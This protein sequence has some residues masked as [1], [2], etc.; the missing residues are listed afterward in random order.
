MPE[1]YAARLISSKGSVTVES[2][3]ALSG[4][5]S[6]LSLK[7]GDYLQQGQTVVTGSGASTLIRYRDGS[8]LQ[9]GPDSRLLIEG[10]AFNPATSETVNHM[11]VNQGT[12]RYMSGF[13]VKK[14]SI[15][16]RTPSTSLGVRG[17]TVEGL[18]SADGAPGILSI[19]KGSGTMEN[20]AGSIKI[21]QSGM[22]VLKDPFTLPTAPDALPQEMQYEASVLFDSELGK[23]P[24]ELPE[25]TKE[26]RQQDAQR[27]RVSILEQKSR[28]AIGSPDGV[29]DRALEHLD[30][31]PLKPTSSGDQSEDV[32][33]GGFLGRMQ[34]I[35]VSWWDEVILFPEAVAATFDMVEKQLGSL[36]TAFKG[37]LLKPS[38]ETL[39]EEETKKLEQLKQ[40]AQ[41]R[42]PQAIAELARRNEALRQQNE[43]AMLKGVKEIIAGAAEIEDDPK[44]LARIVGSAAQAAKQNGVDTTKE[45][46]AGALSVEG[47][48]NTLEMATKIVAA[49]AA[50]DPDAAKKS[51]LA[52]LSMIPETERTKAAV[53]LAGAAAAVA[54]KSAASIVDGVLEA[55]AD[56]QW[57]GEK[58]SASDL[59]AVV[60]NSAGADAAAEVAAAAIK[61]SDPDEI[62]AIT[63]SAIKVAG[64]SMAGSV[65]QSVIAALPDQRPD[66]IANVAA[67]AVQV[68]GAQVAGEIARGAAEAAGEEMAGLIA[69]TVVRVAGKE[70]AAAVAGAVTDA[71]GH[72][73][74]A[75]VTSSVLQVAGPEAVASVATAVIESA[76]G[77]A[78]VGVLSGI[79]SVTGTSQ[80]TVALQAVNQGMVAHVQQQQVKADGDGAEGTGSAQV[81]VPPVL[82]ATELAIIVAVTM[83]DGA[84]PEEAARIAAEISANNPGTDVGMIVAAVEQTAGPQASESIYQ[85][86]A[87]A[88]G[89]NVDSIRQAAENSQDAVREQVSQTQQASQQQTQSINQ[90]NAMVNQHVEQAA[91]I[92]EEAEK[93]AEESLKVVE[94]SS[95]LIEE[96]AI[97]ANDVVD[98]GEATPV[99]EIVENLAPQFSGSTSFT[100]PEMS[101]VGT[102]VGSV[103]ATDPEGKAI[104]YALSGTNAFRVDSSSGRLT[105]ADSNALDY[106]T[107]RAFT[108]QVTASDGEKTASTP[109]TV[110]LS[111]VFE[112]K[113]PSFTSGNSFT[114]D[115]NQAAGA[116][117]TT[118][119]AIDEDGDD[120]SYSMVAHNWFQI[121]QATGKLTVKTGADINYEETKTTTLTVT[122]NDGKVDVDQTITILIRDVNEA[123][124]TVA[125]SNSTYNIASELASSSSSSSINT[126]IGT[127]SNDDVDVGDAHA[128]VLTNNTAS[129]EIQSDQL[130]AKDPTSLANGSYSVT[131]QVTD[132]G[133]NIRTATFTI[134]VVAFSHV[135]IDATPSVTTMKDSARDTYT[136]IH[137]NLGDASVSSFFI[138]ETELE[139]LLMAKLH[140]QTSSSTFDIDNI[141][142]KFDLQIT[143]DL[144]IATVYF[145]L[146]DT[147]STKLGSTATAVVEGVFGALSSFSDNSGGYE[148]TVRFVVKPVISGTTV[149]FDTSVS[150]VDILNEVNYLPN[151]S[152]SLSSLID[153]YNNSFLPALGSDFILFPGD[154]ST[155]QSIPTS[156]DI[157][158]LFR[159]NTVSTLAVDWDGITVTK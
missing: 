8:T 102:V 37:G 98:T 15:R 25:L 128:Y 70:S 113:E 154:G 62:A 54:P 84:S 143:P 7:T 75:T 158:Y 58:P 51:V 100:V 63:A 35:M 142:K 20:G 31:S 71:V 13:V 27:N 18:A 155:S 26:E 48:T 120:L 42:Y 114:I 53:Y 156:L 36:M 96:A 127:F 94:E 12:F 32:S 40:L 22:V 16:I 148:V 88:T 29:P 141:V 144:V 79:K 33:Q 52:A 122:V 10:F 81:A 56:S 95:A 129:F 3:D 135:Y 43:Q 74:A 132:N 131:V 21:P 139:Q 137:S 39:S 19:P 49:A 38:G 121:N 103:S 46:L 83:T 116:L 126:Y 125:L 136:S 11:Q 134:S 47:K 64:P 124:T 61:R 44:E 87:S 57:P 138:T 45:I 147:I 67:S 104:K 23:Q 115:E 77:S 130:H 111:D 73:A 90:S 60:I 133:G 93:Q 105:V 159:G 146:L 151:I 55:V 118:V 145:G 110:S 50:G 6:T 117:V 108:F 5:T 41:Q 89:Q 69:A 72:A 17:T 101:A 112:N 123:L 2:T 119:T 86:V 9:L 157:S 66:L 152:L 92:A 78:A 91:A 30:D 14:P 106:E 153:S 34:A 28:L 1:H 149:S 97:V 82:S 85:A 140:Q 76:G 109:V 59:V 150:F 107:K 4:E 68:A 24:V 99:E 80:T 65:A